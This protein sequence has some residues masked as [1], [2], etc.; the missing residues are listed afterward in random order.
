MLAAPTGLTVA[1]GSYGRG[2]L[3][4]SI[5]AAQLLTGLAPRHHSGLHLGAREILQLVINV[6]VPYAA[7]ETGS[8]ERR[9]LVK[10]QRLRIFRHT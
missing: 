1:H 2:W 10:R 9:P 6:E 3:T 5:H 7:L 8:I 4:Q